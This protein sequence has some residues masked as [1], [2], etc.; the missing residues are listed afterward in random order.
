MNVIFSNLQKLK[1]ICLSDANA[2]LER[3][4]HCLNEAHRLSNVSWTDMGVKNK[5]IGKKWKKNLLW[6]TPEAP[7]PKFIE[8]KWQVLLSH[9]YNQ[10]QT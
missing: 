9:T 7:A 6:A 3:C 1:T 5:F 8:K 2:L 10:C 4:A